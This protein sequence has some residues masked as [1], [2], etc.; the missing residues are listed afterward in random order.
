MAP[1]V[2]KEILVEMEYLMRCFRDD[3]NT[4]ERVLR[5]I[6]EAR[7]ALKMR[8]DSLKDVL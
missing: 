7:D 1:D 5:P 3:L 6:Q 8:Y 2:Y 4:D